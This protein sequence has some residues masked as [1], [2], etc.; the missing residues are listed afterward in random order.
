MRRG[1]RRPT[2]RVILQNGE[3]CGVGLERRSV[4]AG[5]GDT[6][7]KLAFAATRDGIYSPLTTASIASTRLQFVLLTA[8]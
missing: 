8:S 7:W 3:L 1:Y 2:L 4:A 5:L 6:L